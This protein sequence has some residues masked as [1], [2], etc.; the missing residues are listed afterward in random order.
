MDII[1]IDGEK[2][3]DR[4]SDALTR[5][6][7]AFRV[8]QARQEAETETSKEAGSPIIILLPAA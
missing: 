2:K 7:S 4:K 5:A 1:E 8:D 3:A 6:S